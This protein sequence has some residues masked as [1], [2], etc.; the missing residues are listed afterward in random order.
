MN[1]FLKDIIDKG[2]DWILLN[3]NSFFP[4]VN[5]EPWDIKKG[6]RITELATL[7]L[8]LHKI[9]YKHH[10]LSIIINNLLETSRNPRFRDRILRAPEEFV[11][12]CDL[13]GI[14]KKLGYESK[15]Q[16]FL[17]KK[18]LKAKV[19]YHVERQ[20][21]RIMDVSLS[22][23]LAELKSNW[24]VLDRDRI[25]HGTILDQD[26]NPI[27]LRESALYAITHIIMF[28]WG[29]GTRT[30]V[31]FT[32]G[33]K[34]KLSLILP[35]LLVCNVFDRHWDLVSELLICWDC[36]GIERSCSYYFSWAALLKQRLSSGAFPGP[37]GDIERRSFLPVSEENKH[38]LTNRFSHLYHTTLTTIIAATLRCNSN[39]R[40]KSNLKHKSY[41]DA[42]IIKVALNMYFQFC[43]KDVKEMIRL[44]SV[45]LSRLSFD[46]VSMWAISQIMDVKIM[47]NEIIS[48][49]SCLDINNNNEKLM[50]GS[51]LPF[52]ISDFIL[53][54]YGIKVDIYRLATDAIVNTS[55]EK[56]EPNPGIIYGKIIGEKIGICNAIHRYTGS[57]MHGFIFDKDPAEIENKFMDFISS[58]ESYCYFFP[59]DDIK[60]DL[61]EILYGIT[62]NQLQKY[63]LVHAMHGTRCLMKLS[64]LTIDNIISFVLDQQKEDGSFGYLGPEFQIL[65]NGKKSCPDDDLHK[66]LLISEIGFHC[67]WTLFEFLNKSNELYKLF[68]LWLNDSVERPG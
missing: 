20:P 35:P 63:N 34:K 3:L 12:Y 44:N 9:G 67:T 16:R 47:F 2:L 30:P 22:L 29:F 28:L 31:N 38:S 19:P 43:Y 8:C 61:S 6:Q 23:E 24:P 13:Y 33:D 26:L 37:E 11:L 54:V 68:T 66:K 45:K 27:Y 42:D 10:S 64:Y 4:F 41:I 39:N 62:I 14:L 58:C 52:M 1:D 50:Y 57:D 60:Q 48:D 18:A 59:D 21:H 65:L 15:E 51:L 36:V 56:C 49:L 17:L 46:I 25:F 5:D 55:P 32:E 53:T 7:M 40:F